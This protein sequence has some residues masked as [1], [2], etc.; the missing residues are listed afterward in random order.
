MA[1]AETESEIEFTLKKVKIFDRFKNQLN[2]RQFT[3]IRRMLE[4]GAKGF[5][6]GMNA[7]KYAG[8]CKVSKATATR[9]LQYLN[10]IEALLAAGSGRSTSYRVNI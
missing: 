5:Q 7:R 9:D 6:G 4:E 2:D 10:S 1:Q 3:A 8:I